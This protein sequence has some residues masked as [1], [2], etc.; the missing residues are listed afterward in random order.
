MMTNLPYTSLFQAQLALGLCPSFNGG[1]WQG[2]IFDRVSSKKIQYDK[3][4][5]VST[6]DEL[7]GT[8]KAKSTYKPKIKAENC[9]TKDELD[10]VFLCAVCMNIVIDP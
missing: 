7:L 2:D 3:L 5:P 8:F 6:V 9:T 1:K 10:D 4:K